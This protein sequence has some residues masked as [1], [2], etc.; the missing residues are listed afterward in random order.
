[1]VQGAEIFT[2]NTNIDPKYH[3]HITSAMVTM[4]HFLGFVWYFLVPENPWV[5][6]AIFSETTWPLCR[7][8]PFSD[9]RIKYV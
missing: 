1:M 9:T 3:S 6:Q 2:N 7:Y 4:E 5:Y 8:T